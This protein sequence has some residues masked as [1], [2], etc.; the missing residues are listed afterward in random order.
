[1]QM[2]W[3]TESS[4]YDFFKTLKTHFYLILLGSVWIFSNIT[5]SR[6]IHKF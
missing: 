6:F 5:M 1:M 3:D 4:L 2:K